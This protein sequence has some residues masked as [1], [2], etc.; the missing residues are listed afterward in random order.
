MT[1]G[2]YWHS[3]E[4]RMRAEAPLLALDEDLTVF[5]ENLPV[6]F[7]KNHKDWPGRSLEWGNEI[8]RLIQIYLTD[9]KTLTFNLWICASQDREDGRYWKRA[10]LIEGRPVSEFHG[11]FPTLLQE[12]RT[13]LESWSA[14]QLEFAVPL[15]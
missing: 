9:E 14:A 6:R 4:D 7:T 3:D 2:G 11:S 10:F 15:A 5:A 1:N 12:A 13:T 8:R